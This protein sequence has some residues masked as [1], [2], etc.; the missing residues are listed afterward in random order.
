MVKVASYRRSY[1]FQICFPDTSVY[2]NAQGKTATIV[3]KSEENPETEPEML[4]GLS[5]TDRKRSQAPHARALPGNPEGTGDVDSL[6]HLTRESHS[7]WYTHQAH[8]HVHPQNPQTGWN[9]GPGLQQS[10]G[11]PGPP[12][13]RVRTAWLSAAAEICGV[14]TTRSRKAG[15]APGLI[16]VLGDQ[17]AWGRRASPPSSMSICGKKTLGKT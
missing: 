1:R 14:T 2:Q 12:H 17:T 5:V 11:C 6:T 8:T 10:R 7:D 13:K 3:R 9:R 15:P 4:T 16:T